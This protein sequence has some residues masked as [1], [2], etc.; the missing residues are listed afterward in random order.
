[1]KDLPAIFRE[2]TLPILSENPTLNA[3]WAGKTLT[4]PRQNASGF[5]VIVEA[6]TYGLYPFVRILD[7]RSVWHG[8]PWE[9]GPAFPNPDYLELCEQFMGFVRSLLCEESK[10]EVHIAGTTPYKWTLK[11]PTEHGIESETMGVLF[12]NYFGKRSTK[13]YQNRHLPVRYAV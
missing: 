6:E 10:L 1:M 2:Y 12:F 9:P 3:S 8:V 11:Y 5:D 7:F 13:S 4:I